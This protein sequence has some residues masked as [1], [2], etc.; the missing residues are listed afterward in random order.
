[1]EIINQGINGVVLQGAMVYY[2]STISIRFYFTVDEG[3]DVNSL[4]IIL[5][6]EVQTGDMIKY[7]E[8][9]QMYYVQTKMI[10]ATDFD[11]SQ[12]LS[13]IA[14][15]SFEAYVNATQANYDVNTYIYN[16]ANNADE[17][18]VELVK[19]LYAYGRSAELYASLAV[20]K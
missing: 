4:H 20:N 1:M 18:E 14:G 19:A 17:T 11:K 10:K 2:D 16:R 8:A 13:I 7:D 6:N 12:H 5:N 9:Y 3:V 15:D